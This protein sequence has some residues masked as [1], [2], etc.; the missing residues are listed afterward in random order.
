MGK[1]RVN[2]ADAGEYFELFFLPGFPPHVIRYHDLEPCTVTGF[3]GLLNGYAG[4]G[5][6]LPDKEEAHPFLLLIL[7]AENILFNSI[8]DPHT[9]IFKDQDQPLAC[10]PVVESDFR[11]LPPTK[12]V[13]LK[14]PL[15]IRDIR[16]EPDLPA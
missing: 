16:G 11:G 2:V 5:K 12:S 14:Y 4:N 15:D 9:V 8:Q 3:A 13:L 6:N 10:F 7:P 1:S